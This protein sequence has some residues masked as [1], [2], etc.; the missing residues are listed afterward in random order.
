MVATPQDCV[1]YMEVRNETGDRTASDQVLR[2]DIDW[3]W[4]RPK[5][6]RRVPKGEPPVEER[7]LRCQLGDRVAGGQVSHLPFED[8]S[9]DSVD[10]GTVF[11]YARNDEALAH[12]LGRIVRAGGAIALSVPATGLL[13]GL[14]SFNLYRYLVD[15]SGRGLRPFETSDIGWRRHYALTDIALLFGDNGFDIV[16]Q[17]RFAVGL[18]EAVRLGGLVLFRWLLPSRDRYRAAARVSNRVLELERGI[19][20]RHGF[21]LEVELRKRDHATGSSPDRVEGSPFA[22]ATRR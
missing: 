19:S 11:A 20:W 14:D 15:V 2:L 1:D 4:H 6:G 17:R 3:R 10:C 18:A 21:W 9:I 5:R 8:A 12:E 22:S 13:A 16:A 7:P